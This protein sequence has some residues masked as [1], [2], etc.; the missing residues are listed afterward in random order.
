MYEKGISAVLIT[1]NEAGKLPATLHALQQV[2]DEIIVIDSFSSDATCE[3]AMQSGARVYQHIWE[4]YSGSKNF[5]NGLCRF[6]HILSLDADEVLDGELQQALM[7]EKAK[8]LHGAY[9]LNRKN[10]LEG[11]WIKHSGWYPDRKVR[12]FPTGQA[13]WRGD[14]V[15]EVLE[16]DEGLPVGE[17][18]GHIIHHTATSRAEHLETIS[19]YNQLQAQK[20]ADHSKSYTL[21][22]SLGQAAAVFIRCFLLRRGFLDGRSGWHIAWRSAAGRIQRYRMYKKRMRKA[23]TQQRYLRP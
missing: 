9:R 7:S 12:L 18:S 17:L 19:R 15:H 2:A 14:Y 8:G 23:R 4:G 13:R 21:L 1:L 10:L 22:R 6:S 11:K 5:G 20:L 16:L 3:I